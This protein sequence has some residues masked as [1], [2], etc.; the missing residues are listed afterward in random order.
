MGGYQQI[1]E[2]AGLLHVGYEGDQMEAGKEE[3]GC[4]GRRRIALLCCTLL[5]CAVLCCAGRRG[6]LPFDSC[7]RQ[8]WILVRGL[9]VGNR[10]RSDSERPCSTLL[11][12]PHC[13][14]C[15]SLGEFVS[16]ALHSSRFLNRKLNDARHFYIL[17]LALWRTA[18][19][20]TG[21]AVPKHSHD[22]H[23]IQQHACPP[24]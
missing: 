21:R 3:T 16:D 9:G 19:I 17:Q 13:T 10:P 20:H 8:F 7:E 23:A 2:W 24:W 15:V 4:V 12:A 11:Q 18:S 5:S 22:E 14:L 6:V 1:E